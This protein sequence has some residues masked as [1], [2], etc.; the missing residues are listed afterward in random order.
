MLLFT[1]FAKILPDTQC[2]D[3]ECLFIT[4]YC[5]FI[6]KGINHWFLLLNFIDNTW[7][8]ASI[9][10]SFYKKRYTIHV[11]IIFHG[12]YTYCICVSSSLRNRQVC[13]RSCETRWDIYI[14][15]DKVYVYASKKCWVVST[16]LGQI[17]TNP[18]LIL[19]NV[20]ISTNYELKNIFLDENIYHITT[21]LKLSFTRNMTLRG[22]FAKK[23]GYSWLQVSS[24]L[25]GTNMIYW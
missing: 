20:Y 8:I 19:I 5:L 21:I 3:K 14:Y 4:C 18:G 13:V 16:L 9:H 10:C 12:K 24:A 6:F 17:W 25:I 2:I 11:Y 1:P 22:E 23:I 7:C 15:S